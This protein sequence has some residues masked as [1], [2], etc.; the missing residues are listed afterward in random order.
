MQEDKRI[1]LE[2]EGIVYIGIPMEEYTMLIET[3]GKYEE[4][5]NAELRNIYDVEKKEKIRPN[6]YGP[7]QE[8]FGEEG[9]PNKDMKITCNKELLKY[10]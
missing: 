3:K 4:L 9:L 7:Y 5:K 2:K 10:E 8:Y 6:I 1:V